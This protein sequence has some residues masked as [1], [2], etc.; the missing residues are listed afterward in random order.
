MPALAWL[1][2]ALTSHSDDTYSFSLNA[3][4]IHMSS[5]IAQGLYIL[6]SLLAADL[7][8]V[9]PAPRSPH[10]NAPR[11]PLQ[12]THCGVSHHQLLKPTQLNGDITYTRDMYVT[13]Y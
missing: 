12:F 2:A 10:Y 1:A 13:K 8:Y 5:L 6:S 4:S 9:P 7:T 11:L 3:S